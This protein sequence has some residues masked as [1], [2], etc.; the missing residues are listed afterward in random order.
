LVRGK[1]DRFSTGRLFRFLNALGQDVEIVVRP[2]RRD[3][4]QAATRVVN[5]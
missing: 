4:R 5:Q 1:L 2:R 3:N